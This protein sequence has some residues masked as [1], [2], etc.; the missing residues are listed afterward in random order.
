MLLLR[1][2][3]IHAVLLIKSLATSNIDQTLRYGLGLQYAFSLQLKARQNSTLDSTLDKNSEGT[4][5]GRYTLRNEPSAVAETSCMC[6]CMGG[7]AFLF[8]KY[9]KC[10]Q[11]AAAPSPGT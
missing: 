10:S 7:L 9:T 4:R 6:V 3:R 11:S 2:Q 5:S 1:H 8:P